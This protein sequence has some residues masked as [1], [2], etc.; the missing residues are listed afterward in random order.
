ML[1]SVKIQNFRRHE[2]FK[3]DFKD[4]N[5]IITGANGSGKTSII[6]A[7]YITLNGRSWRSSFQ[8]ILREENDNVSSWWRIDVKFSDGEGR[9][10]K[11]T[12]NQ[13]VFEINNQKFTR[14]PARHKKP[15]IL[16]EPND[17]QLLYGSPARRR[18]FFDRF[19]A[20]V[21]P[22][23]QTNLNKLSRILKQRNNLLKKGASA[24]ELFIWDIQLAE[25]AERII[26]VR[27]DWI[28]KINKKVTTEY[29]GISIKS[30]D[31]SIKYSAPQKSKQQILNQL[32][33]D[34]RNN[35]TVTKIGP[36]T[37]DIKFK[38]NNHDAKLTASRGESRTIIFATLATMT[39]L[40]NQELGEKVYLVF[41]DIDSELD[42]ERKFGVYKSPVF[43]KN[44]LF[45][46]TIESAYSTINLK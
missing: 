4:E 38:I 32:N 43:N 36:Q 33:T 29:R 9:T 27:E 24:N 17:L 37:H 35:C 10:I 18:D 16:F 28:V 44:Y 13:K 5:I 14:L 21:E 42:F 3:A 23:H 30:D 8:E 20:Q 1:K 46:T 6:E 22:S 2:E 31:I 12:D 11:F 19:I 25:L 39:E 7:I 34:F 41:D 15:V 26:L 40:L 45:A